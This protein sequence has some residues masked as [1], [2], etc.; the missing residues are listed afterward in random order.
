MR[1]QGMMDD[2]AEQLEELRSAVLRDWAVVVSRSTAEIV[3]MQ[4]T[5]SWRVTRPLRMVRTMQ[6]TA[7]EGGLRAASD[8]VAVKIAQR[9]SR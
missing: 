5:V 9:L 7:S 1:K 4:S 8:L 3:D 6:R 2:A